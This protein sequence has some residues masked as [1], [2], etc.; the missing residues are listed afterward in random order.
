MIGQTYQYYPTTYSG[1]Q[2][3][4]LQQPLTVQP[5]QPVQTVQPLQNQVLAWVQSE[6]EAQK[7]PLSAGQSIFLMNQNENYLY[8][9][10]V[11]QL[12]KT[13]F[14]KKK[15]TDESE[16]KDNQIDLSGYIRRDELDTLIS[17]I[18]QREVEKK[19]SE[20]SFKAAKTRRKSS[21]EEN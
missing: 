10:S 15:L 13:V 4:Q 9:K 1:Y 2:Y 8:A 20:T 19:V 7:Y 14:I 18:I 12:G 3:P 5:T 6:E 16:P 11:D 21:N 17:G